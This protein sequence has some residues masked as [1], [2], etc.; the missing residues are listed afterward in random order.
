MQARTSRMNW[1]GGMILRAAFAALV[2][3][4]LKAVSSVEFQVR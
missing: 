3:V 1:I 2:G 4:A